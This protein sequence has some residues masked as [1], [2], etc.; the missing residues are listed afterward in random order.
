MML[1]A[2]RVLARYLVASFAEERARILAWLDGFG[3]PLTLFRAVRVEDIQNIDYDKLGQFWTPEKAAAHSP[4][5]VSGK[6]TE[7]IIEAVARRKNVD[8]VA[9]VA[10]FRRYPDEKEVRMEASAPVVVKGVYTRAGFVPVHRQ[11]RV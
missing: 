2:K 3:D 4:Y 9:T 1:A 7:V 6:G 11:G 5:G 10:T 8:E